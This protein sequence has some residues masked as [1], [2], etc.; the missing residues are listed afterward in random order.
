MRKNFAQLNKEN[1]SNINPM[2][3]NLPDDMRKTLHGIINRL[4]YLKDMFDFSNLEK[5]N[6]EN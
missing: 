5:N 2:K 3:D 1:N 4:N 6:I